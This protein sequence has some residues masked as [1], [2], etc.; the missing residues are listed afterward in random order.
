MNNKLRTHKLR[1][2]PAEFKAMKAGLKKFEWRRDNRKFKVG[3]MLIL[4]EW[5]P[6]VKDFTGNFL[7]VK[8]TYILR[9]KFGCPKGYC[10]MSIDI[11]KNININQLS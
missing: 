7:I 10:I 1:T 5:N 2:W 8:I 3:D 4:N 9:E 11:I 6:K